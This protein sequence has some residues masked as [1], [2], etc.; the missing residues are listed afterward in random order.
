MVEIAI[1]IF[2][3]PVSRAGYAGAMEHF[4]YVGAMEHVGYVG[5]MELTESG[6]TEKQSGTDRPIDDICFSV[7]SQ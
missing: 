2:Q 5:A 1:H 7:P 3:H 4:G 6:D